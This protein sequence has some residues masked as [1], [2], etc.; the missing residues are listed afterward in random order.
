MNS[1]LFQGMKICGLL[2]SWLLWSYNHRDAAP[3][4]LPD[5]LTVLV[6]CTLPLP[7][8]VDGDSLN[9]GEFQAD[10]QALKKAGCRK[11]AS[12]S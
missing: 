1:V 7:S 10:W 8:A 2:K 12:Q 3:M 9:G 4:A 5:D 6:S 11:A